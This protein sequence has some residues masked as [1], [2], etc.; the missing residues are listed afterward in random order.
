MSQREVDVHPWEISNI[1]VVADLFVHA[2][3]HLARDIQEEINRNR[4]V[5]I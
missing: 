4:V 2:D 5:K 3:V 1:Q